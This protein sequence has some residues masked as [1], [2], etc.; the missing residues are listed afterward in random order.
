MPQFRLLS[1]WWRRSKWYFKA[2]VFQKCKIV[3]SSRKTILTIITLFTAGPIL[4]YFLWWDS[5]R[6]LVS[7]IDAGIFS[8]VFIAIG[9][10]LFGT[11][12]ISVS[13]EAT[14]LQQYSDTPL[15]LTDVLQRRKGLGWIFI[16]LAASYF[17]G[18][19]LFMK[20]LGSGTGLAS[21]IL[22]SLVVL[23]V[24]IAVIFRERKLTINI[25][26][27]AYLVRKYHDDGI[28]YIQSL[29]EQIETMIAIGALKFKEGTEPQDKVVTKQMLTARAFSEDLLLQPIYHHIEL[30]F[31]LLIKYVSKQEHSLTENAITAIGNLIGAYIGMRRGNTLVKMEGMMTLTSDQDRFLYDQHEYLMEVQKIAVSHG[32]ERTAGFLVKTLGI[33]IAINAYPEIQI[34]MDKSDQN[35]RLSIIEG[36]LWE[37]AKEGLKKGMQNVGMEAMKQLKI[38][39]ISQIAERKPMNIGFVLNHILEATQYGILMN[40]T[41]VIQSA[42][43]CAATLLRAATMPMKNGDGTLRNPDHRFVRSTMEKIKEMVDLVEA[44]KLEQRTGLVSLEHTYAPI[45]HLVIGKLTP[46]TYIFQDLANNADS[47]KDPTAKKVWQES[48]IIYGEELGKFLSEV[49]E[50]AAKN[51]S[52]LLSMIDHCLEPILQWLVHLQNNDAWK[53]YK[54]EAKAMLK[55]IIAFYGRTYNA[56]ERVTKNTCSLSFAETLLCTA[57]EA[58][59]RGDFDIAEECSKNLIVFAR[60]SIKKEPESGYQPPRYL[61][62][63]FAISGVAK[64]QGDSDIWKGFLT[65]TNAFVKAYVASFAEMEM[66]VNVIISIFHQEIEDIERRRYE[67]MNLDCESRMLAEALTYED[68]TQ[69]LSDLETTLMPKPKSED[70]SPE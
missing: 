50:I 31:Q 33:T 67:T 9:T 14:V 60:Q 32:D 61:F 57:L 28:E 37:C 18:V 26:N 7:Q 64:K 59:E 17:I 42:F 47:E 30:I 27:P 46:I 21:T 51:E 52:F 62:R 10:A 63:S 24:S 41:P 16:I 15:V 36:C 48:L 13:Q 53:D 65:A 38:I 49:G 25:A 58:L 5:Y 56:H 34:M 29:P 11:L 70:S 66:D 68:F 19:S 40:S 2:F 43:D 22:A 3:F 39:G 69:L 35:V 20:Q 1:T 44:S 6:D 23:I 55:S 54:E 45:F 4:T 12:A 8:T